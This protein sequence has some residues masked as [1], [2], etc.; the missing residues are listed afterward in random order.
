MAE[1]MRTM[2]NDHIDHL[3]VE[4]KSLLDKIKITV[5]EEVAKQLTTIS[6]AATKV[7][8]NK[9][10]SPMS[11]QGMAIKNIP[12]LH[13]TDSRV[14]ARE[15]IRARQFILDIPD[16]STLKNFSQAEVLKRFNSDKNKIKMVLKMW[17]G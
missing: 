13:G 8:E 10:D 6:T 2:V 5:S 7:V 9:G 15:G 11:Y 3:N 17:T 1:T 14:L 16:N 12:L 4:T